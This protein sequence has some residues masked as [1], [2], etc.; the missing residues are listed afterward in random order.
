[1]DLWNHVCAINEDGR[2]LWGTEGHVEYGTLFRYIDLLA[3]EHAIN[4]R[5]QTGLLCQLNK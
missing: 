2:T 3:A 5:L 1:M 4:P